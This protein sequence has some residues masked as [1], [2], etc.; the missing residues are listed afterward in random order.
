MVE[1]SLEAICNDCG[2]D[3]W[4]SGENEYPSTIECPECRNNVQIPEE[5]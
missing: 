1:N 2:E 3:I 4:Y 5:A